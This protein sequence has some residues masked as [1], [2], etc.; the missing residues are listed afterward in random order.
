MVAPCNEEQ[1]RQATRQACNRV[2]SA[3]THWVKNFEGKNLNAHHLFR[4]ERSGQL[5]FLG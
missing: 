2:R 5:R 3:L 1:R 4:L